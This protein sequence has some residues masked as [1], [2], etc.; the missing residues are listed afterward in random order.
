VPTHLDAEQRAIRRLIAQIDELDRLH[1]RPGWRLVVLI[2]GI[3]LVALGLLAYVAFF[4]AGPRRL[5]RPP[6]PRAPAV[7]THPEAAPRR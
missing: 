7:L 6:G 5:A 2:G 4:D 3:F 1:N